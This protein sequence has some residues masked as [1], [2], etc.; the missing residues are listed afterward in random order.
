M[1]KTI[2]RL[3]G[4]LH[5]LRLKPLGCGNPAKGV[6]PIGGPF[7]ALRGPEQSVNHMRS[8]DERVEKYRISLGV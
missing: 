3:N 8:R 4:C 5:S 2:F 1:K 7:A 6:P